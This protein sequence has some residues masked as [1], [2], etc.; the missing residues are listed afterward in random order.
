MGRPVAPLRNGSRYSIA[1]RGAR[2]IRC[3]YGTG[4]GVSTDR[5][6]WGRRAR[7]T[8]ASRRD[9]TSVQCGRGTWRRIPEV[10]HHND[11]RSTTCVSSSSP[12]RDVRAR[13]R[14]RPPER[15][16][17]SSTIGCRA[18]S[19]ASRV[20]TGRRRRPPSRPPRASS[21]RPPC[22]STC[23]GASQASHPTRSRAR[24]WRPH[25]SARAGR[26]AGSAP[27]RP[28]PRPTGPRRRVGAA[29]TPPRRAVRI[30]MAGTVTPS[31]IVTVKRSTS[32]SPNAR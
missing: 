6:R 19:P 29:R 13:D 20:G 16:A 5:P 8:H 21:A 26:R 10:T 12:G 23:T 27:H 14:D 9:R 7:G 31:D 4:C 2:R 18:R 30:A 32:S 22:S 25:N 15:S 11:H 24:D 28:P 1:P 17:T 3:G